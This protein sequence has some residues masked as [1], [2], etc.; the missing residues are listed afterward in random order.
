MRTGGLRNGQEAKM[1]RR[2]A[3]LAFLLAASAV[4]LPRQER[5]APSS[6]TFPG[7]PESFEGRPLVET[8]LAESVWE[9]ERV[10]L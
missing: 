10:P 6:D 9:M 3:Q 7:W 1:I 8:P 5:E 4:L 2:L